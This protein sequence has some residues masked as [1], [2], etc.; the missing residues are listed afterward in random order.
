MFELTLTLPNDPIAP[1]AARHTLD[2]LGD[3]LPQDVV[4]RFQIVVSELVTNALLHAPDGADIRLEARLSGDALRVAVVQPGPT[5]KPVID[6]PHPGQESGWGL[7]LV[8]QLADRWGV[9]AN[10]DVTAWCE[11]DL[12]ASA[13]SEGSPANSHR[14]GGVGHWSGFAA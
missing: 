13:S 2:G 11:F 6:A 7:Y 1:G 5:F 9:V 4:E 8:S 10:D 14:S 3:R 12:P